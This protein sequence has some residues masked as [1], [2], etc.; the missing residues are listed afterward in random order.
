MT[1]LWK[2][3]LLKNFLEVFSF[4]RE[5]CEGCDWTLVASRCDKDEDYDDND[6]DYNNNDENDNSNYEDYDNN[7]ENDDNNDED[8]NNND[9]D[10]T[11][12]ASRSQMAPSVM[13]SR[14]W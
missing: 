11:L 13:M 8:Y 5:D 1:A 10:Y 14:T 12:V 4:L 7:D 9:E 6:E 3:F 2:D